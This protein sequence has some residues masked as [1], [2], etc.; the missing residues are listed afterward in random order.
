MGITNTQVTMDKRVRKSAN[1]AFIRPIRGTRSNLF[2]KNEIYVTKILIDPITKKAKGVEYTST[3]TGKSEIVMAKKEVIISAGAI[4]S[5]KLLMV[6]GVGP[7]EELEKHGINIIQDLSVG[8]NLQDHLATRG[9][10]AII[11]N[12]SS[13]EMKSD[14]EVCAEK[15]GNLNYYGR[16]NKGTYSAIGPACLAAYVHTEYE[17]NKNIPDTQL[18]LSLS[19]ENKLNIIT[20]LLTPKSRGFIKLNATD[21]IWGSPLIYPGYL[22]AEPDLKRIIQG[23]RIGLNVFNTSTFKKNNFKLDTTTTQPC[24]NFKYNSDEYWTCVVRQMGFTLH[25]AVGTCK[26]GPKEDS[27]AVVDPRLRVYGIQGLRV[28]DASIM[29]VIPRGN[30]N[31]PTIMIAEKASDMIKE[32]WSAEI[33]KVKSA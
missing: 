9:V 14:V 25:H 11:K 2:V 20:G 28:I 4:N 18:I 7:A 24:D 1:A 3:A 13:P 16:T 17:K 23:I 12:V 8:H 31:A 29:P 10:Y 33:K 32:D 6:S 21:P 26:M 19:V 30:T 15:V 27:E 22:T 5:P